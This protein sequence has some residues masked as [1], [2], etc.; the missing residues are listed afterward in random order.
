V[1]VRLPGPVLVSPQA[2]TSSVE[3]LES[4]LEEIDT[5]GLDRLEWDRLKI[6]LRRPH[7]GTNYLASL[8]SWDDWKREAVR[9][10]LR[11]FRDNFHQFPR[12]W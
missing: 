3:G 12:P 9:K 2:D 1:R 10:V 7:A 6:V 5:K 8:G 11:E 4:A